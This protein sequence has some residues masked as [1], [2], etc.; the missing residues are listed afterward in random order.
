M[1]YKK[2][3]KQR[4]S[5]L[6]KGSYMWTIFDSVMNT[7]DTVDFTNFFDFSYNKNICFSSDYSGE[8]NE[9][10][11]NIYTFSFQS[12]SSLFNWKNEID[13]LKQ[14]KG[15]IKAAEYK[16]INRN[17]RLGKLHDW[18]ETSESF[19]KGI[20]TS[21]IID[22]N[23]DSLFDSTI[24]DFHNKVSSHEYYQECNLSPKILEKAFRISHFSSLIL[25]QILGDRY[26]FFW[27][28]D[29]DSISQGDE[30][31]K[32]TQK[33]HSTV[34]EHYCM[35][36][37]EI[38]MGY[39][40]PFDQDNETDNFSEDF[41]SLSDLISGALDDYAN[42]FFDNNPQELLEKLKPK[43]IEILTYLEKIPTFIYFLNLEDSVV[44]CRRIEIQIVE[45]TSQ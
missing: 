18:F 10:K 1:S 13:K 33:I 6:L 8:N 22:K 4:V 17:T 25:S 44:K 11:N 31:W 36:L 45:N 7:T 38:K 26:G 15:Y 35:H 34:F 37:S 41:I 5:D 42:N 12:Y 28:T 9:S 3:E 29:K 30:R 32:F 24:L 19:F 39:S 21:F 2:F 16:K 43:S 14:N 20:I 40:I 23:I 27:M